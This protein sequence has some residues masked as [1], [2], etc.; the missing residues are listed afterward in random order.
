MQWR[1]E[2]RISIVLASRDRGDGGRHGN[3]FEP[4]QALR[5]NALDDLAAVG[6]PRLRP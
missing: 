2:V 4:A 1:H 6:N 3:F 5:E